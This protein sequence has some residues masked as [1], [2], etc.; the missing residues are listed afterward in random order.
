M[1]ETDAT[2]SE[3]GSRT[4]EHRGWRLP[5]VAKDRWW[6]APL[7]LLVV[8]AFLATSVVV[9]TGGAKVVQEEFSSINLSLGSNPLSQQLN[10][11]FA[12][13]SYLDQP[14][15]WNTTGFINASLTGNGAWLDNS[16]SYGTHYGIAQVNSTSTGTT[17]L[18][19]WPLAPSLG[20]N[21]SYA[22]LDQRVAL[23]G[24]GTTWQLVLSEAQPTGQVPTSGNVTNAAATSAQNEVWVQAFYSAG[25]YT[26]L[27]YDWEE[28]AGGF[29]TVT[30]YTFPSNVKAPPLQFFEVYVYAQPLQTVVSIV[31]TTNGAV[32]GSTPAMHPVLDGN[33]TKIGYLGDTLTAAASSVDS[34]M[35]LDSAFFVDHNTYANAPGAS[36]AV[37]PMIAG[38]VSIPNAA[39][40]DPASVTTHWLNPPNSQNSYSS[41]KGSLSDFPSVVNSSSPASETSSLINSTA[42][43]NSTTTAT[44]AC[45]S[46]TLATIRATPEDQTD[47]VSSTAYATT[48]TRQTIQSQMHSFL[49]NYISANT[50]V[51]AADI[52]IPGMLVSNIAVWT[53]FSTQASSTIHD[54]LASAIPGF[55]QSNNLALVNRTTGAI[56]AGADIG[57]FMDLSTGAVYAGQTTSIGAVFDPVD[58]QWY[59]SAEAAGFPSGSGVGASGAIF[60]PG[61]AAFLGWA[62]NGEPEFGVGGCFIVCLGSALTGA[63]SAVSNFVGSAAS[64]VSNA[65]GGVTNTASNDVIKPVSG[66]LGSDLSGV[67]TDVSKAVD[68]VMPFFGGTIA[69]IGGA[70]QGTLSHT[71]S[72]ITSGI[73]SAASG[74][75]GAILSGVN[76]ISNTIYHVGAAAGSAIGSLPGEIQSGLNVVGNTV[77]KVVSTSAAVL[78]SAFTTARN[79]AG[80]VGSAILNGGK[81]LLSLAG[82]AAGAVAG[83]LNTVGSTIVKG[84]SGALS[85]LENAFGTAGSDIMGAIKGLAAALNPFSW[86]SGFSSQVAQILEYV[87][88]GVVAFVLVFAIVF[89]LHRRSKKHGSRQRGGERG[90]H[91][92]RHAHR[93]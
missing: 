39:P 49:T 57:E 75:A 27:A 73:G 35:I 58:H 41:L 51:P 83:A 60:V 46:G 88:I 47:A 6:A 31:N 3:T 42:I 64:T 8:A 32:V 48:W 55:L 19:S 81:S 26:F 59:A 9:L 67:T 17:A 16:S 69:N 34:A 54:Y 68:Q 24:T 21:V 72:G 80:D 93:A 18:A 91:R 14:T 77:G 22:F 52:E 74:A 71:L 4:F 76:S 61:Q 5:R 23:N 82:N 40:F 62:A 43:L 15:Q 79:V 53:Q 50:G 84:A 2:G 89:F 45:A 29:Q 37:I 63:A 38:S 12:R 20:A 90:R 86:F 78:S 85:W 13:V 56:D 36:T 33:L 10:I 25:N 28:K 1:S 70:V 7:A 44:E 65:V 87:V 30:T 92:S 66:T 11:T